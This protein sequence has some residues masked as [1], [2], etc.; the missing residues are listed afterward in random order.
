M[1]QQSTTCYLLE[2]N[3]HPGR[4]QPWPLPAPIGPPRLFRSRARVNRQIER[5]SCPRVLVSQHKQQSTIIMDRHY[6]ARMGCSTLHAKDIIQILK[7][8]K[9]IINLMKASILLYFSPPSQDCPQNDGFAFPQRSST[10]ARSIVSPLSFSG[11]NV[12]GC[13]LCA[14]VDWR[15]TN[16]A[17]N[18]VLFIFA[19]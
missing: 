7:P 14:I 18:F 17:I 10:T 1:T 9:K 16:A 13:L 8:A 2:K 15:P 19:P 6:S 11:V 4:H 5:R 3:R 12:V